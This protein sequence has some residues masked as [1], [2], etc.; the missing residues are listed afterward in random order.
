MLVFLLL[1]LL[2]HFHFNIYFCF[3]KT[4]IH[5]F[6]CIF[7]VPCISILLVC[8]FLFQIKC[9]NFI[10]VS[11][12]HIKKRKSFMVLVLIKSNNNP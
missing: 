5:Y 11:N 6:I 1:L 10:L 3:V 7:I 9:V 12:C 2:F 4:L 8:S